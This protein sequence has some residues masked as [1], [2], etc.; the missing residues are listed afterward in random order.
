MLADEDFDNEERLEAVIKK[1]DAD[2]KKGR[3]KA[4]KK[5]TSSDPTN[6]YMQGQPSL[7]L[8]DTPDAEL[9]EGGAGGKEKVEAYES[10]SIMNKIKERNRRRAAL[11]DRKSKAAQ[12]RMKSI[13][14]LAAD[15]RVLKKWRKE[16]VF[17][18]D[19]SYWAIYRKINTAAP[20]SDEEGDLSTATTLG[21][22]LL[23]HTTPHSTY[24]ETT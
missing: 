15:E 7:P 11:G 21:S 2:V 22:T 14:S 3:K 12:A 6:E 18:A 17:G 20:F 5:D 4:K 23:A 10:L 24:D 1:L 16:D 19:Y 8:V 13:A 9:D